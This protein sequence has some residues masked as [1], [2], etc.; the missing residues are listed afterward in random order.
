MFTNERATRL[1]LYGGFHGDGGYDS[2]VDM[3]EIDC[4]RFDCWQKRPIIGHIP[5]TG[6]PLVP[7]RAPT[8][9]GE[10]LFIFGGY[11]GDERKP[12]GQLRSLLISAGDD[13]GAAW[14]EVDV[15]GELT[16]DSVATL[17][18]GSRGT[19]ATPRYGYVWG[20]DRELSFIL[21]GGSG[22]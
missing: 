21:F 15:W 5:R 4:N 7:V 18:K 17:A 14:R 6:R 2:L 10:T 22:R 16:D 9:D 11:D 12:L 3:F 20:F 19:A 8:P 1:Y 13:I